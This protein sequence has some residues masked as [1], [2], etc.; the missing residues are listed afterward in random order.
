MIKYNGTF[1]QSERQAAN[2]WACTALPDPS[3]VGAE[4]DAEVSAADLVTYWRDEAAKIG[5]RLPLPA[6]TLQLAL[7]RRIDDSRDERLAEESSYTE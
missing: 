3:V 2:A 7:I 1:Y 6:S 4:E 5:E